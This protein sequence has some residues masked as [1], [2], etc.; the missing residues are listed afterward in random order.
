MLFRSIDSLESRTSRVTVFTVP[1]RNVALEVSDKFVWG[2]EAVRTFLAF[3]MPV[4]ALANLVV[5]AH[6]AYTA[7]HVRKPIFEPVSRAGHRLWNLPKNQFGKRDFGKGDARA[8]E[9]RSLHVGNNANTG[10]LLSSEPTGADRHEA[11]NVVVSGAV[12]C[13]NFGQCLWTLYSFCSRYLFFGISTS[14]IDKYCKTLGITLD[15]NVRPVVSN[16]EGCLPE[17]ARVKA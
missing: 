14:F 15:T 2:L 10:G 9:L 11:P 7:Y 12:D 3:E 8:N 1:P 4:I 13:L 6:H 5:V 17:R 16:R